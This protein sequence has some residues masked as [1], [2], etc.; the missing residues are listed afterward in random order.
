MTKTMMRLLKLSL[1]VL[2]LGIMAAPASAATLGRMI[3]PEATASPLG[4]DVQYYRDGRGYRE[5]H[6]PRRRCWMENRRVRVQDRYG[7][8]FVQVRPVRVCR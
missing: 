7:R 2:P 8:V 3:A 1:L 5:R 4:S 6:H